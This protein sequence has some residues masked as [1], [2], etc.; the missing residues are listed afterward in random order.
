M[1]ETPARPKC[2]VDVTSDVR[3]RIRAGLRKL[4]APEIPLTEL[5]ATERAS[6]TTA[7]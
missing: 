1:V 4:V 6:E 3:R 2:I 7:R 5:G